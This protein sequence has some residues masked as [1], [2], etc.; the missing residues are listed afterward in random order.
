MDEGDF[1]RNDFQQ[2]KKEQ[3]QIKNPTSIYISMAY[4]KSNRYESSLVKPK[5]FHTEGKKKLKR[6]V[7][8]FES[9]VYIRASDLQLSESIILDLCKFDTKSVTSTKR[10]PMARCTLSIG[11]IYSSL[12]RLAIKQRE[13]KILSM[14]RWE[15][16][17]LLKTEKTSNRSVSMKDIDDD[18]NIATPSIQEFSLMRNQRKRKFD[19]INIIDSINQELLKIKNTVDADE[20]DIA[21]VS[22]SSSQGSL[23]S[24]FL[25]VEREKELNKKKEMLKTK[26]E[27]FGQIYMSFFPVSWVSFKCLSPI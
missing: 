12:M 10:K 27:I 19:N 4:G 14:T 20:N 26:E 5:V 24:Y 9:T 1:S 16:E 7:A 2:A 23:N 8:T 21:S 17:S 6:I 11:D 18:K 22:S 25:G 15:K 13:E 3:R